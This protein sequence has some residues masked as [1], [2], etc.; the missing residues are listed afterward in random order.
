MNFLTSKRPDLIF[1]YRVRSVD[2][3]LMGYKVLFVVE[4][5]TYE[6]KIKDNGSLNLISLIK[7]SADN[8]FEITAE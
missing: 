3:E 7:L 1:N 5:G 4:K 6:A 2:H 8:C